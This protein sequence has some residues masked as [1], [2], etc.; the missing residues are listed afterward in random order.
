MSTQEKCI[1]AISSPSLDSLAAHAC[2]QKE[3]LAANAL[4]EL[5]QQPSDGEINENLARQDTEQ[6]VSAITSD[7][8]NSQHPPPT[9]TDSGMPGST[10]AI[11]PE[12][13]NTDNARSDNTDSEDEPLLNLQRQLRATSDDDIPLSQVQNKL[14]GNPRSSST[15]AS[16]PTG[17]PAFQSV[18]HGLKRKHQRNCN[19]QC[20]DCD[21][22]CKSQ[23][24][25]NQHFL[26]NHGNLKCSMCDQQCKTIS[27]MRMHEYE[28]RN[29]DDFESCEDC[30][31]SFPFESQLKVHRKS[32]LTALEH[33]NKGE[34]VKHQAVHSGNIW[35]CDMWEYEYKNPRN[36]KAHKNTH[37]DKTRYCCPKCNCG[38][39]HYMQW[40]CHKSLPAC[41]KL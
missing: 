10:P 16:T 22:V 35:N 11:D 28:H 3:K 25:L 2:R 8:S 4:L 31:K 33:Q 34:A 24:A 15:P 36:L 14:R 41:K 7:D 20:T 5:S 29:K 39:N 1:A 18:F 37:G 17:K 40:K 12:T 9:N 6:P 23:G 30:G 38:F 32:H 26:S 21:T 19:F 27:A 13:V